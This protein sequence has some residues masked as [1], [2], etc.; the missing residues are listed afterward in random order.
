VTPVSL[1]RSRFENHDR[2]AVT[3]GVVNHSENAVKGVSL[4]LD[5]DGKAIQSQSTDV[6]AGGS[7]S[8]VFTPFTIASRN[9]RATVRLPDDGLKRDN[10]FHFVVSPS[11][12]VHT[13]VI[14]RP[15]AEREALYLGRA[16]SISESPRVELE[17]R[18]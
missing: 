15:G 2:V 18:T 16:L 14:T 17:M 3:A 4:S 7:S 12:P 11:E 13:F 8:V 1:Q 6:A 10:A 9:M 5:V